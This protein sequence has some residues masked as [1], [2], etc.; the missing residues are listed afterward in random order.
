MMLDIVST[1][2]ESV[3]IEQIS[4]DKPSSKEHSRVG[5]RMNQ[6]CSVCQVYICD[7]CW[8]KFHNEPVPGLPPCVS[9]KY[10]I[11][12]QTRSNSS[13][14]PRCP[15]ASSPVR[16]SRPRRIVTG[17]SKV[18]SLLN[19]PIR[20]MMRRRPQR[21]SGSDEADAVDALQILSGRKR[22]N[23]QQPPAP[24]KR[25]RRGSKGK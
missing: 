23:P 22:S 17:V 18:P 21:T 5:R 1:L 24:R 12:V 2:R 4:I 6:F 25:C 19:S 11:A 10:N 16:V 15:S 13:R 9:N 7:D 14:C 3:P 20:R 8:D